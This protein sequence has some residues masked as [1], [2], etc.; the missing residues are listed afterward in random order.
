MSEHTEPINLSIVLPLYNPLPNWSD[1]IVNSIRAIQERL[2]QLVLQLIVVNDGS[3]NTIL[4]SDIASLEPLVDDFQYIAY[5]QNRGKGYALR[6]GIAVV[7]HELCIYTDIDFPYTVDSF[8]ALFEQLQTANW[9]VV[10]GIRDANYYKHVPAFRK[11]ISKV[12]RFFIK[13]LLSIQITDTQCG[14][15]GFNAKGKKLFLQTTIDRYLFDLEFVFL[16]SNDKEVEISSL[17]VTLRPEIVFS[18]INLRILLTESRSFLKLLFQSFFGQ[19][20]N[21]LTL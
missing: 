9:D 20:S 4:E 2:P 1:T 17:P 14:I 19:K 7:S 13:L 11:F 6:Q 8:V 18:K 16:S 3:N 15:K 10:V 12:L 5:A 21:K